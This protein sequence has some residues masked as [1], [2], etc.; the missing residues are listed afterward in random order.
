MHLVERLVGRW[1]VVAGTFAVAGFFACQGPA[2][3]ATQPP[4]EP[5]AVAPDPDAAVVIPQSLKDWYVSPAG[6]DS[7]PGSSA[8]PFRTITRALAV[9]GPGERILVSAGTYAE[10]VRITGTVR[11]GTAAAPIRLQGVNA[12]KLVPPATESGSLV[13]IEKPYWTVDGFEADVQG[14]AFYA[15]HFAGMVTG[16]VLSHCNLHGGSSGA[17]VST[18]FACVGATIQDNEIHHFQR[19]GEDAHG[20][21]VQ[22][23]SKQITILRNVL[24]DNSGDSIQCIGPEDLSSE[25]P[26]DGVTIQ[27]NTMYHDGEQAVDVK[28]C[29]NVLIKHNVMR[30]YLEALP[31]GC[32]VVVHMSASEVTIQDND[33]S[34]VGKAIAIGGNHVGPVPYHVVV[35]QNRIRNV[36]KGNQLEGVG[37]RLENSQSARVFNNTFSGVGYAAIMAGGGTGGA[38][39]DLMI[40]DNLVSTGSSIAYGIYLG[41]Y[42]NGLL[43]R[44]N[45]FAPGT[46]FS[47]IA[48]SGARQTLDISG[49]QSVTGQDHPSRVA[50]PRLDPTTLVP[51][52]A[53][54]DWG[55]YVGISY[56]GAGPDI[57]ARE[58][59]CL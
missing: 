28:T 26:A 30:D 13:Q 17:G 45:L 11:A 46:L 14:K 56:C 37:I 10:R 4:D 50:D 41:A 19:V 12:P 48:A 27:D 3:G 58:T 9:V 33:I 57:G 24:H 52:P 7:A 31:G 2:R 54:V 29:S 18:H 42:M 23:G 49:W 1:Y 8:Q 59:G 44:Y 38:T 47:A 55:E 6:V 34:N 16:S 35:K 43:S 51:G 5:A 15:A 21:L 53:A 25:P 39:S 32:S 20:I 40:K 36:V 22:P